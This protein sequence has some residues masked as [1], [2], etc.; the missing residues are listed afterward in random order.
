MY[1]VFIASSLNPE[2]V[3][4][5]EAEQ[6]Q[7]II[8]LNCTSSDDEDHFRAATEPKKKKKPNLDESLS[9]FE[10]LEKEDP[11]VASNIRKMARVTSIMR[12][13]GISFKEIKE[14][15][16]LE[17]DDDDIELLGDGV[18]LTEAGK[19]MCFNYMLSTIV[20][21]NKEQKRVIRAKF[22]S[23]RI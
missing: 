23:I 2:V 15:R 22:E 7:D 9:P 11:Q 18:I 1:F 19:Y 3:S 14:V 6:N 8:C 20:Y 21:C 5:R 10:K 4:A 16:F 17:E 12:Q 13:L